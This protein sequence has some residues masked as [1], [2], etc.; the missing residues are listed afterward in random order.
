MVCDIITGKE[1]CSAASKAENV[2]EIPSAAAEFWRL[3]GGR[4]SENFQTT[5]KIADLEQTLS[6]EGIG[7]EDYIK[8]S[9]T[10]LKVKENGEVEEVVHGEICRANV[11]DSK[12][13]CK[14]NITHKKFLGP[15]F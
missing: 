12:E 11:F 5:P 15:N 8:L 9:N 6:I 4:S 7:Y 10:I 2:Q 14:K 3:L 1:V 13:V